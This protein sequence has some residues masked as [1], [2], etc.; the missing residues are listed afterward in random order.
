LHDVFYKFLFVSGDIDKLV[1]NHWFLCHPV[2]DKTIKKTV[3]QVTGYRFQD[4]LPLVD[5]FYLAPCSLLLY[6]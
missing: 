5:Y 2:N 3:S 1:R 6:I 4:Y